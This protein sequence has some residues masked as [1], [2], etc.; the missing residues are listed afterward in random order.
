M[1]NTFIQWARA[2]SWEENLQCISNWKT[3]SFETDYI[4]AL[5]GLG[6][7]VIVEVSS[8]SHG[9]SYFL[10]GPG[11]QSTKPL[12]ISGLPKSLSSY[13]INRKNEDI[14]PMGIDFVF[15]CDEEVIAIPRT[16]LME[17]NTCM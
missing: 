10:K 17:R 7:T 4:S 8:F 6:T 5:K 16:T 15:V 13:L 14:F 3:P 11:I 2:R 1:I 12:T 9:D